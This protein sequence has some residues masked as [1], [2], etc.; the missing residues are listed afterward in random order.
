MS[1][2]SIQSRQNPRI[3]HLVKLRNRSERNRHSEFLIEGLR[4][5]SHALDC[6]KPLKELYFC[7]DYFRNDEA[8]LLIDKA[9]ELT[10]PLIELTPSVFDKITHRE[11]PD[12]LLGVAQTWETSLKEIKLSSNP[13][14]VIADSIEKPGNLGSLMRSVEATGADALILCNPITDIFNPNVVRASQGLLFSLPIVVASAEEIHAFLK[15][16]T[17]HL[18]ATTPQAS[19][20]YWDADLRQ[21]TAILMGSEK[22]GL[23]EHWLN[24]ADTQVTIPLEGKADSL[25]IS[26]AAVLTLYEALRQ[27][28]G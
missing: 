5:L 12:G 14:L 16:N 11:S 18:I 9:Q 19:T 4:E 13:L 25:N 27:R 6:Q 10:I 20:H 3:K 7:S 17:I 2:S 26:T 28:K 21:P 23:D 8:A 1:I 22:D 24:Q 15:E